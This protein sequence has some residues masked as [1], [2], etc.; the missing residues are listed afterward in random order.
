MQ[1]HVWII[2][3]DCR[4]AL[5]GLPAES[6]HCVVTS[7]PYW[8]LR[9]YG[10]EPATW[11]DGWHGCLGL[12]PTVGLYVEHLVEVFADVWQVLRPDGTAWLNLGDCYTSGG[13]AWRDTD[14]KNPIRAMRYRPPTP[15]GLKP[16]DLLGIPW[17]VAFALQSAGWWVRNAIVWAKCLSGGT[18]LYAKTQKGEMPATLKDLVHLDPRTVKLWD[19]QKWNQVIAWGDALPDPERKAKGSRRRSAHCRGR[20]TPVEGDIEVEFRNG[21]RVGCTRNHKW[22]TRRGDVRADELV[23]GDVVEWVPLPEPEHPRQPAMLPDE[24]T[25]W[26]IG[27]YLAEGSLSQ[28]TIQL[29]GHV[30]ETTR[31]ARLAQIVE[32]MD[33]YCAVSAHSDNGIAA[34][35]NSAVL[36]GLIGTYI[37]GRTARDRHLHPRCWARS[38]AFLRALLQGY[39]EG[40][41]WQRPNGTWRI[42]FTKNDALAADLRTLAARL[43]M[44]LRLRRRVATNSTTGKQHKC[45]RGDLAMDRSQRRTA[46]GEV[47]AIRQ[48]RARMFHNVTLA[49]EP[50]QFAL[51]SGICTEN[52]NPMPESVT[53]RCTS[54]YE[55]IFLMARSPR[56]FYDAEAVR[57]PCQ[58]GPSDIRKMLEGKDRIGGKHKTL[59]DS[60]SKASA[61]T[62][63]GRKRAVG[64]PTGRNRR[65]VWHINTVPYKGAHFATFP[66]ALAEGCIRAGTSEYGVCGRCG[67]PWVRVLERTGEVDGSAKGSRFDLGKTGINGQG[68]VQEGE[69]Y[70]KRTVGWRPSCACEAPVVPATVLDPFGGAGTT[71]L[72]AARLGRVGL[73]TEVKGDYCRLAAQRLRD[74]LG[75]LADVDVYELLG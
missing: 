11:A 37:A 32:A 26:F 24:D 19:G 10:V 43:G 27:M 17:R 20:E 3:G 13:R 25:G 56:Y 38:N 69:R 68:R 2:R 14:K 46:D 52:S 66:P 7:P 70:V 5:R 9:D 39:L 12:E 61:S 29:S 41:G 44:S 31:N 72:A 67:A 16:K 58:S 54:S 64:S 8:G 1:P 4:Q 42:A 30:R 34:H 49:E 36:L 55:L 28:G 18:H 48:S 50:H 23:I 33:G 62:R 15:D 75:R 51:A 59:D 35:I 57:E 60:H 21:E 74:K 40:D 45:W 71:G 22:P 65:D 47:V 73:L 63:I 6:V 53:D